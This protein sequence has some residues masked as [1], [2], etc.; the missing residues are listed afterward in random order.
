LQIDPITGSAYELL[1]VPG[2]KDYKGAACSDRSETLLTYV[3]LAA[4]YDAAVNE[5]TTTIHAFPRLL[6][7]RCALPSVSVPHPYI[8]IS[9]P[10]AS[11]LCRR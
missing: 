8:V 1:S 11:F 9:I 5:T 4:V 10:L 6:P 2:Q 3:M 7:W